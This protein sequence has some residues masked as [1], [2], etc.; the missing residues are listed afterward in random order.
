MK[1]TTRG[2]YAISAI[3]DI[4]LHQK[5]A[6]ISL[7]EISKRQDISENYLRQLFMQL[8]QREIVKSV[9]GVL[10]GY[11]IERRFDQI[12]LLDIVQA[13]EGD[14]SIVP[15]L[16]ENCDVPCHRSV[17]CRTKPIWSM[18]NSSIKHCLEVITL[19]ELIEMYS[20]DFENFDPKK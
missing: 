4:A 11:L 17:E 3:L 9:R 16:E 14:I 15:C 1:L 13:V 7:K 12:S 18:L 6:P 20:K 2:N 8:S 19:Q 10:G 5:D